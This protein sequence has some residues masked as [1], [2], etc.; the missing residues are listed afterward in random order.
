MT[1]EP[2][3]E[4]LTKVKRSGSGYVALCPAHDDKEASLSLTEAADGKVLL[5]C[6]AG[7]S[8]GDVVAKVGLELA[9]LFPKND[10]PRQVA[11]EYPYHDVDG[12][13]LYVVERLVPKSFRQKR[14]TSDGWSWKLGDVKRVPYRLPQVLEAVK[15]KRYVFIVEGE[16]DVAT[17]ER[18]GFTATC[19]AGGAGGVGRGKFDPSWKGYFEG[20][21]VA[22]IPDNDDPGRTHAEAVCSL[23]HDSATTKLVDLGGTK[24]ADV[25]DWVANGGGAEQLK[26]LVRS[27]A[28]WRKQLESDLVMT[29]VSDV[30]TEMVTWLWPERIPYGKLTVLEGDPG[31]GKSTVTLDLAARVSTGSDMPDG[32]KLFGPSDV[33]LISS[34]DG[35][36]DTVRP[37]LEAAQADLRRVHV[38]RGL[39]DGRMIEI[40][41]DLPSLEEA[42]SQTGSTFVIIDPLVAFLGPN[43]D[44]HRDQDIRRALHPLIELADRTK[45]AVLLM[46]HLN[47]GGG[48]AMYRGGGSIGITGAVRAGMVIAHHPDDDMQRVLAV[49]KSN[50]AKVPDS[51]V[52]RLVPDGLRGVA[53]V[54]WSG[55]THLSA[56]DCLS[57]ALRSAAAKDIYGGRS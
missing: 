4:R 42:I 48:K 28:T 34:E 8:A 12:A 43:I 21:Y 7:C 27:T 22:V 31:L 35:I 36:S 3:L 45:A 17:L 46:R 16:K 37:R 20:G 32:D 54:Q 10:E 26:A 24:G 23:L 11:T 55:P 49:F 5:N 39:G 13:I 38:I 44:S 51:L 6:H 52:Y 18:L 9:D 53:R 33:I 50:L 56:D 30:Q 1:I 15:A 14:P 41:D 2:L 47:K 29:R 25:T 57:P 19:N 40:P